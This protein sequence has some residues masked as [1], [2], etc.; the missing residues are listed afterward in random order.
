[1]TMWSKPAD[2]VEERTNSNRRYRF[3][4][5]PSFFVSKTMKVQNILH[6]MYRIY[7]TQ[8]TDHTSHTTGLLS[9]R[10]VVGIFVC[11]CLHFQQRFSPLPYIKEE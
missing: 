5:D 2:L 8:S 1:M 10:A 6:R 7:F 3:D 9:L 11:G 4:W